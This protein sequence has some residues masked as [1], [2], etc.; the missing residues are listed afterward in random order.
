M[1]SILKWLTRG[2]V[3]AAV[4]LA[5]ILGG[6]EYG[7]GYEC[8]PPKPDPALCPPLDDE[9]CAWECQQIGYPDGGKCMMA[10]GCC[11]CFA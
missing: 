1:N 10:M 9:S 3:A 2:A 11:T 4:A 5:L 7:T 8:P 6:P